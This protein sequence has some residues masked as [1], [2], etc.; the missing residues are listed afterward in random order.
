MVEFIKQHNKPVYDDDTSKAI[1]SPYKNQGGG[2][3]GNA[4]GNQQEF[5][6][7]LKDALYMFIEAKQASGS[8][9]SRRYSVGFNRAGRIMDQMFQAGFIGPPDG[10]KP[11]QVLITMDEYNA[12]FGDKQ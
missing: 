1:K 10:S 5:D 3:A 4:G 12:I 9:I 8:M 7:V 6:P 11:R 2:G